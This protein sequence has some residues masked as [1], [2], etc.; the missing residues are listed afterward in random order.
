MQSTG[1]TQVGELEQAR[2][3]GL[4]FRRVRHADQ[5]DTSGY[6][7]RLLLLHGV[8]GNET[9]LASL[10]ATIDPRVD[11]RLLRAPLT[12]GPNGFGWFQVS[13]QTGGPVIDALQAETSRQRLLVLIR[14]LHRED[15]DTPLPTVIAGF[16]QGG[17]MSA[18]VGLTSPAD[19]PG[20]A[21]LSGR[22]LPEI[23]PIVASREALSATQGFI[24]HGRYD[25]KLPVD[26]ADK[27][28]RWLTEL[29]VRHET[30]TYALGH[31]I[32]AQVADDF[33]R[34]LAGPLG[35]A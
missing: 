3:S 21:I 1:T 16:S 33:R 34:W 15:G 24:G 4:S 27:A 25:D 5:G 30:H 12:F 32:D 10:A 7:A 8:G 14:E 2:E 20:F 31:E 28:T 18:C 6:R 13:F 22:I 17:I 19:V 23:A 35:L 11:V 9:N 26:W 29:G